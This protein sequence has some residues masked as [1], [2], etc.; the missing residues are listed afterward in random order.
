MLSA[1]ITHEPSKSWGLTSSKG[2]IRSLQ[3]RGLERLTDV[4]QAKAMAHTANTSLYTEA[5]SVDLGQRLSDWCRFRGLS[6]FYS[7][8]RKTVSQ[9]RESRVHRSNW[10]L[11]FMIIYTLKHQRLNSGNVQLFVEQVNESGMWTND[12]LFCQTNG[13]NTNTMFGTA[14]TQSAAFILTVRHTVFYLFGSLQ[15]SLHVLWGERHVVFLLDRTTASGPEIKQWSINA[16]TVKPMLKSL[17][18]DLWLTCWPLYGYSRI[19]GGYLQNL[20]FYLITDM[21]PTVNRQHH[22][23][24]RERAEYWS[25]KRFSSSLT[26]PHIISVKESSFHF[27]NRS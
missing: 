12:Y 13:Q 17:L 21:W 1:T 6:D 16:E 18:A 27:H 2:W 23:A 5:M 20:H 19:N 7:W 15:T 9:Y 11:W 14:H 4:K 24:E 22:T 8:I 26:A 25:H 3:V 10:I